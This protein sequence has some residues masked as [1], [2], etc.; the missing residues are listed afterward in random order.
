MFPRR[1]TTNNQE[2]KE[3]KREESHKAEF[4]FLIPK[5]PVRSYTSTVLNHMI[6][7]EVFQKST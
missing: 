1:R 5:H 4:F 2:E 7:G 6:T 3:K